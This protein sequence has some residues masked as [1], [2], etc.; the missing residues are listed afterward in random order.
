[1][2][3]INADMAELLAGMLDKQVSQRAVTRYPIVGAVL[4]LTACLGPGGAG[5]RSNIHIVGGI[6]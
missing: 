5:H 3:C 2:N 6:L 1:M 4:R